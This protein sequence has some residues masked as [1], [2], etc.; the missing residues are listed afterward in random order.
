MS[1]EPIDPQDF[2]W[3]MDALKEIADKTSECKGGVGKKVH[4]IS[5]HT[6]THIM[7]AQAARRAGGSRNN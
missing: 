7:I 5:E 3:A 6:I 1:D 4:S 2:K